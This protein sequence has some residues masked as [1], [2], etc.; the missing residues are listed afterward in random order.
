MISNELLKSGYIFYLL[1]FLSFLAFLI[2]VYPCSSV[3]PLS[4]PL[5]LC[6]IPGLPS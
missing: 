3:V 1:L 4:V 6:G 2:R 5:C